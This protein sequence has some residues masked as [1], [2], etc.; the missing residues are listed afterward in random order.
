[1]AGVFGRTEPRKGQRAT[2]H[3]SEV[4]TV[5]KGS[6]PGE[7]RTMSN[8]VTPSGR[9]DK[10]NVNTFPRK[11]TVFLLPSWQETLGVACLETTSAGLAVIGCQ[12]VGVDLIAE[13]RVRGLPVLARNAG[14]I[15]TPLRWLGELVS[16]SA[17]LG[18]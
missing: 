2:G 11:T 7:R 3:S 17:A 1:M 8:V 4:R 10:S 14:A 9:H 13:H 5:S 16:E 15:A 12:G 6:K 18:N